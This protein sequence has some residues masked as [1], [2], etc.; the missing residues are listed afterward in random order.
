MQGNNQSYHQAN[1]PWQYHQYPPSL[2]LQLPFPLLPVDKA[3]GR[4]HSKSDENR[5]IKMKLFN[6]K[7]GENNRD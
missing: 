6:V 2:E 3:T 4:M 7:A 1:L 5:G